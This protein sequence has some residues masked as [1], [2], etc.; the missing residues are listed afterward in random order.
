[1]PKKEI[2]NYYLEMKMIIIVRE[3]VAH[4]LIDIA[5]MGMSTIRLYAQLWRLMKKMKRV[6]KHTQ[7]RH[8]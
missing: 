4:S 7:S 8:R 6:K 1:M 5:C 3:K 2:I